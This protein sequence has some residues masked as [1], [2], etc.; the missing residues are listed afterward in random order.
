MSGEVCITCNIGNNLLQVVHVVQNMRT[1]EKYRG[2]ESRYTCPACGRAKKFTRYIDVESGDYFGNHVGR[3]NRESSCGYHL[4]PKEF[5]AD[6]QT[7]RAVTKT[8]HNRQT[9]NNPKPHYINPTILI[10]TL[11]NYDKNGFVQFLLKLFPND[12]EDIWEAVR[13]FLIGTCRNGKTI[14][15]QID[16]KRRIRTGKIIEYNTAT[17]KRRRNLNPNWAHAELKKAGLLQSGFNLE[18]CFF[19]EHLLPL[20]PGLPV[21]IVEAEKTAVIGSI[22]KAVFSDFVWLACG[23]KSYLNAERLKR[24]GTGRRVILFPDGDG[25]EKWQIVAS[26]ARARGLNV[27][28]SDL[29]ENR[30]TDAEK[31]QGY[32]LADYIIREQV[33]RNCGATIQWG[34]S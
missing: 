23:G 32:D 25:F 4:T 14:F 34:V 17:G 12:V 20:N 24:L 13:R 21:A 2:A 18:Q 22:C 3:C 9:F 27:L 30:A 10:R 8:L 7:R 29:I 5:L 26:H 33:R 1:L 16:Q 31:A 11:T 15:W 6:T 19:G 28:V